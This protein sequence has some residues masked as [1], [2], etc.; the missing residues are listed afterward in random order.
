MSVVETTLSHV[1]VR[2]LPTGSGDM[3]RYSCDLCKRELDPQDDLRYVVKME[4]YAAF[5][6]AATDGDEDD[7]DHLEEI[8]DILERLE[9]SARRSDRRRRLSAIAVRSLPRVPQE[10]RQEP[11][12]TR[13]GQGVRVQQQ[14]MRRAA[15]SSVRFA[16]RAAR[17]RR[18]VA[19]RACL[20]LAALQQWRPAAVSASRAATHSSRE[21]TASLAWSTATRSC[22]PS[23]A[24]RVRL[25]GADTPET[26]KPNWPVEPWGPEATRSPGSFSP[27]ARSVWSSTATARQVRADS[28]VCLGGRSDA[29]RG[30]DPRGLAR[31]EMQYHYSAARRPAF[32]GRG[33]GPGRPPRHLVDGASAQL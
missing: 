12:G 14:L 29:Q 20:A 30:V 17:G 19:R 8:Q 23:R 26:V 11:A 7:R 32:A 15:T 2:R 18:S 25:I 4:V 3:I 16:C 5:D 13:D 31:A 33:R 21:R 27:A 10:V 1:G 6:P 9:D 28:G 22:W 24:E